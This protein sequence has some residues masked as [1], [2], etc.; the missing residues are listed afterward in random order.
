MP[1]SK[2]TTPPV[3]KVVTKKSPTPEQAYAAH[4]K[5]GMGQAKKMGI[6][7]PYDAKSYANKYAM[8][9]GGKKPKI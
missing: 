7:D 6:T 9:K 3:G 5:Y 2:K 8:G 1:I 4:Y